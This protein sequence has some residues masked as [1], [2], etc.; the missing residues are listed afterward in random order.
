MTTTVAPAPDRS[1]RVWLALGSLIA[2]PI[3]IALLLPGMV[4]AIRTYFAPSYLSYFRAHPK[5]IATA[6]LVVALTALLEVAAVWLLVWA[7]RL[8]K[9]ERARAPDRGN[10]L[11]AIELYVCALAALF[12]GTKL[13][14]YL[15]YHS[16]W[17]IPTVLGPS[18]ILVISSIA[19]LARTRRAGWITLY[20]LF[21]PLYV[22]TLKVL[23][24]DC[25]WLVLSELQ[26]PWIVVGFA[27]A[28]ATFAVLVAESWRTNTVGI[29]VKAVAVVLG[30]LLASGTAFVFYLGASGESGN[31]RERHPITLH[32]IMGPFFW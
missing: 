11:L 22:L 13:A 18:S 17:K 9:Y 24:H 8:I 26:A 19:V 15:P 1:Q 12:V 27:L 4:G 25:W 3:W 5:E 32:H 30:I 20:L 2:G 16:F 28:S 6:S 29:K 21:V 23:S 10:L 7:M 14:D 31:C